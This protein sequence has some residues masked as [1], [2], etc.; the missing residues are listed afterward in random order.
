MAEISSLHPWPPS[1]LLIVRLFICV[2][3][4][5]GHAK[6]LN[7]P[8]PQSPLLFLKPPSCIITKGQKVQVPPGCTNLHHEVELGVVIQKGGSDLSESVVMDHVGGYVLGLDMTAR[9][10]QSAAKKKGEPWSVAKGYD[11]FLPLGDF[12][13]RSEIRDPQNVELWLKVNGMLKQRG[14]TKDHIFKIPHLIA[15]ISTIFR[16]EE[17]D[18]I[19]TGTPEGVSSVKPGDVMTAGISG[20]PQYDIEFGVEDR[21]PKSKL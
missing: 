13:P 14:N 15:H 18:I 2:A 7:N 9:E 19:L 17:G 5:S 8:I 11:T 1:Y 20:L 21:Y 6:E 4:R 3:S 12:I 16:L 10:I